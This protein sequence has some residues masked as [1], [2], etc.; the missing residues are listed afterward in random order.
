MNEL[1]P[2][3]ALRVGVAVA[4]S[5]SPLF[6]VKDKDGKP[7]GVTIDLANALAGELGVAVELMVAPNTG[8]LVDALEA[9]RIDVSFMPVD[10]ERRK[11]LDFGPVYFQVE[12]TYIVTDAS[13]IKTVGEVDRPGVRVIGIANTTTIRAAGRTLSNTTIKAVQSIGEAIEMMTGGKADAFALSRDSLPPFVARLPG[14]RIVEGGFQFTGIA[15]A[16]AK[17]K[18]EALATVTAF[19]EK[20]KRSGL[21]KDAFARAGLSHLDV[22]P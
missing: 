3:G 8:E 22:A 20:A 13:G 10:E 4:P 11:R 7:R 9:G 16:V 21:V 18:P 15:V 12:S 1:T 14:S 6:V 19:L 5:P 2:T 17:G